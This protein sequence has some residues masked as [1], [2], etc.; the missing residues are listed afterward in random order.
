MGITLIHREV[1]VKH[2]FIHEAETIQDV[3]SVLSVTGENARVV[4]GGTA[5]TILRKAG[6]L[7]PEHVVD[8]KR[9]KHLI[10]GEIADGWLSL[11]ALCTLTE[12][13]LSESVKQ[14]APVLA[15]TSQKVANRR[16]RNIATIGGNV[17][18]ADPT[19]D[20]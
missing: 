17:S 15:S 18:E 2:P 16:V 3:L 12:I 9:V 14:Y 13:A 7:Q 10:R 11:G 1:D 20:P 6:L 5:F 19:S 8:L 4:A